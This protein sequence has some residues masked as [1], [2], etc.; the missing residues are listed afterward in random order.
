MSMKAIAVEHFNAWIECFGASETIDYAER[1][2]AAALADAHPD[3]VDAVLDLVAN[4]EQVTSAAQHVRDGGTVIST[5]FGVT[6]ELSGQ[7]RITAAN[8][9]LDDKP[10]RP[11]RVTEAGRGRARQRR[12]GDRAT[13]PRRRQRQDAHPDLRRVIGP[14]GAVAVRCDDR[15]AVHRGLWPRC[16]APGASASGPSREA[17]SSVA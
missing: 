12:G 5:T 2:V 8:Y 16:R 14:L 6:D 13:P 15:E 17:G 3:G 10:A 1:S 7:N 4:A 11:E 9:Q